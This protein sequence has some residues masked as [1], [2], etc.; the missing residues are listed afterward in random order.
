VPTA[1]S[2]SGWHTQR[3]NNAKLVTYTQRLLGEIASWVSFPITDKL[4]APDLD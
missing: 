4:N 1:I 3:I 2:A